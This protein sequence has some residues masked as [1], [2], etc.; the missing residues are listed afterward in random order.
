MKIRKC[1]KL[2]GV[3]I[4]FFYLCDSLFGLVKLPPQ[5]AILPN[6]MKVVV[7]E[8][9]S[10]PIVAVSLIFNLGVG[11]NSNVPPGVIP[12]ASSLIAKCDTLS[13]S[14][15]ELVSKLEM[16]GCSMIFSEYSPKVYACCN[17][18][19]ESL[20]TILQF[21]KSVGF[22]KKYTQESLDEAKESSLRRLRDQLRFPL[23]SGHL[24]ESVR[25]LLFKGT[26][27]GAPIFG[28]SEDLTSIS[29]A[30]MKD[31]ESKFILP[32]NSVLVIVGD[33]DASSV[34]RKS[35]EIMGSLKAGS[36]AVPVVS[37]EKEVL[38]PTKEVREF[39]DIKDSQIIVAFEAPGMTDP[40]MPATELWVT[41]FEDAQNSW[42]QLFKRKYPNINNLHV[43]YNSNIDKGM[44]TIR[45]QCNNPDVDPVI[46]A[47]LEELS[48]LWLNPPQGEQLR[49]LVAIK[50]SVLNR[51]RETRLW[52]SV[53][54][55]FAELAKDFSLSSALPASLDRITSED[56]KRVAKKIFSGQRYAVA[57][58]QP[59]SYQAKVE[60]S[61]KY[62]GLPNGLKITVK[63]YVGSELA[64]ISLRLG[65][66]CMM[67]P[68]GKEGIATLL[69]NYLE[70][71]LS[72]GENEAGHYGDQLDAIGAGFDFSSNTDS[73]YLTGF[74]GKEQLARLIPLLKSAICE[75]VW[76]PVLYQ[77]AIDRLDENKNSS[78]AGAFVDFVKAFLK[79][80]FPGTAL[81]RGI[82]S[83]NFS[84]SLSFEDL[85]KFHAQ[86]VVPENIEC[87]AVGNIDPQ[88]TMEEIKRQ[89]QTV[90]AAKIP[91]CEYIPSEFKQPFSITQEIEVPMDCPADSVILGVGY[92]IPPIPLLIASETTKFDLAA[93]TVILHLL[94]WS[95]NGVIVKEML[96]K[97]LAYEIPDA[98]LTSS[99]ETAM[100]V[101]AVR[102][103]KAKVA[104]AKTALVKILDNVKKLVVTSSEIQ[105]AG[106]I[107]NS[108]MLQNIQGA[109]DY[110][111]IL[112]S[113]LNMGL[114]TDFI[115]KLDER[116]QK[117]TP[118]HIRSAI[119]RNFQH[120]ILIIGKP[121]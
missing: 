75:P 88:Q 105:T 109:S 7:A 13:G 41:A 87:V 24:S 39:L 63:P 103:P 94:S 111:A 104:E 86:W 40:D 91:Q 55:G 120:Y 58:A 84:K 99:K 69:K 31:F 90:P 34:F 53:D 37:T 11:T 67:E 76:E 27:M 59:L 18:P 115:E 17:G 96:N 30:T 35:M 98:S 108:F 54:L 29:L 52:K 38:A 61:A 77:K 44:F 20:E 116:F 9:H 100:L 117:L 89:F 102:V 68:E 56:L 118:E 62:E 106:K 71:T 66:G 2:F 81:A 95:R 82:D 21:L 110:A 93:S 78:H 43:S 5:K 33:V 72:G 107:V 3:G 49:R 32:N 1:L 14:R 51:E 73:L 42:K 97:G 45:W 4:F 121:N 79:A 70:L 8:D 6:G 119:Q 50:R 25:S 28:K 83:S 19:S 60:S 113:Y 65:I 15:V 36:I 48:S 22:E 10:L 112:N 74:V 114:K 92:R 101:F 16:Q 26:T 12:I 23:T 64:A 57:I 46:A 80:A 85:K 47:L